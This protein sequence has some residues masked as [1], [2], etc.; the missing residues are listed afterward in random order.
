MKKERKRG[1]ET[2]AYGKRYERDLEK[3]PRKETHEGD[4][5]KKPTKAMHLA[6]ARRS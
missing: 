2:Y 3:R 5:Y 1:K 6:V 4:L